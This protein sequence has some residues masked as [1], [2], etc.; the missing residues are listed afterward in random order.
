MHHKGCARIAGNVFSL[1]TGVDLDDMNL[2]PGNS[3]E[4]Q[5]ENDHRQ[6]V[7]TELAEEITDDFDDGPDPNEVLPW[8]NPDKITA[9]WQSNQKNYIV[10]QRYLMALAN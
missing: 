3:E 7:T 6:Q 2:T 10:G 9:W 4:I 1:I 8:P 5:P